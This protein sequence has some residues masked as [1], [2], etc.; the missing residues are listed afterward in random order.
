[1]GRIAI[2]EKAIYLLGSSSVRLDETTLTRL[3]RE[4]GVVCWRAK[5]PSA[6][7]SWDG[8]E[9]PRFEPHGSGAFFI[10]APHNETKHAWVYRVSGL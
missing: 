2:D 10:L 7:G 6:G 4:T 3:H 9:F 1:V 5:L 8:N